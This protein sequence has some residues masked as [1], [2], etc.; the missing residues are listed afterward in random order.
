MEHILIISDFPDLQYKKDSGTPSL[1]LI[2]EALSKKYILHIISPTGHG[3]NTDTV[4][5]HYLNITTSILPTK[6]RI[7]RYINSKLFWVRFNISAIR[8]SITF[9]KKYNFKLVYGAGCTSVYI[10]S[11]I[12]KELNIPSI[13]RLFGTYLYP[14]LN[15][16]I[17]LRMRFEEYMAFKSDCTKFIITNDGTM[18][19]RVAEYFN[20]PKNKLYFWRN[21]VEVQDPIYIPSKNLRIVSMARLD[22]WKRVD[23]I[24][25]AFSEAVKQNDNMVL[26]IIGDG[27]EEHKLQELAYYTYGLRDKIMFYGEVNRKEALD[28]IRCSDVFIS[29]NDYSNL[30]N[31]LMEAMVCGKLVIALNT[32][33]TSEIVHDGITGLLVD[34]EEDLYK[35]ILRSYNDNEREIIGRCAKMY[36]DVCFDSWN[37]RINKEVDVCDRLILGV[38]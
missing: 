36:A 17:S 21:G 26:D 30:S 22:S 11:K 4:K 25:K 8:T 34:K 37:M 28:F 19:D 35:A 5:Y 12:G 31:S 15:N 2:I 10:A 29:T 3:K 38:L 18:G 6:F 27:T 14:F 13:G 9:N 23:R 24:I 1:R 33:G 16:S 7:F 32:G 20:I